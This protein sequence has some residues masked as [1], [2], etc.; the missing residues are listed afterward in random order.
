MPTAGTLLRAARERQGLH[1]DVLAAA[2]KVSPR[3]LEALEADQLGELSG[4]TFARALAL[5]VCR[6]LRIDARP[7]LDRM[8]PAG[9]FALV[10]PDS[11]L[12]M[13]FREGAVRSL[14]RGDDTRQ[15]RFAARPLL[16]GAGVL[17]VASVALFLVPPLS[18]WGG[19][20]ALPAPASLPASAASAASLAS[21]PVPA[22]STPSAASAPA[23]GPDAVVPGAGQP[24]QAG[25]AASG[26]MAETVFSAPPAGTDAAAVAAAMQLQ[27]RVTEASWIEV[28]DARGTVLLSRTV[29][30]GEQVGLNGAEPLA[31]LVGN[32][33]ATQLVFRGRTVDLASR[34]RDNVA[35]LQLP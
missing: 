19:G 14:R 27:L 3:K 29:S 35:R 33:A 15:A 34:S 22:A 18:R 6:T 32:A 4:A 26:P 31:L 12:N 30:P 7:V 28:R 11:G 23:S 2:I 9:P 10:P 8:P 24:G 21:P 13:P 5:A 17:L 25:G 16:W 1:I 20:S